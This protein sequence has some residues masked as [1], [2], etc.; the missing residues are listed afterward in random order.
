M[1]HTIDH[2]LVVFTLDYTFLLLFE[3][4]KFFKSESGLWRNFLTSDTVAQN[5]LYQQ[6]QIIDNLRPLRKVITEIN[7]S[8]EPGDFVNI[9]EPQLGN[10]IIT[11]SVNGSLRFITSARIKIL[12]S[13]N[14]VGYK[15]IELT[16]KQFSNL[17][18]Q[19]FSNLKLIAKHY[20][21]EISIDNIDTDFKSINR[22]SPEYF[23]YILGNIDNIAVAEI[24][25][26]ILID[27][28]INKFRLHSIEID[29][30]LIP[31]IG[32]TDLF[33]FSLVAQQLKSNIYV[34]DLLPELFNSK[35]LLSNFKQKIYITAKEATQ[36]L[37][38]EKL[39]SNIVEETKDAYITQTIDLSKVKLDSFSLHNQSDIL[40]IML[41]NGTFIQLPSL[42]EPNNFQIKV[43]GR[44]LESVEE[45]VHELTL[46]SSKYYSLYISFR[47]PGLFNSDLE[48][49]IIYLLQLK[50]TVVVT[51]NQNGIEIV[52][53]KNE[54][55]DV[56]SGLEKSN[57]FWDSLLKNYEISIKIEIDNRQKEFISGKK[58]GKMVKILNNFVQKPFIQFSPFNEYN[59]FINVKVF[60]DIALLIKCIQLIE[61]E[62]P[63]EVQ[64]NVP[65]VFHKSIIGNGGSIIQSIMKKYNVFIKF[66]SN[67]NK[68]GTFYSFK[69]LNNV[70]IKCPQ[71]NAKNISFVKRDIAQLVQQCCMNLQP[72]ASNVAVYHNSEFRLLKSHYLLLINNFKLKPVMDLEASY[73]SF[74]S[75]PKSLEDF[76]RKNYVMVPIKGSDVKSKQAAYKLKDIL[77]HN[78]EF[79]L[80]N[81]ADKFCKLINEDNEEFNE[82]IIMP[83]RL[84]LEVELSF[85]EVPIDS[86]L[87]MLP[88]IILS[89]YKKDLMKIAIEDLTFYLR[90]K[91]F[92]IL[93]KH[94]YN[95]NPIVDNTIVHPQQQLQSQLH[96][97]GVR[98]SFQTLQP[99]T[100][101]VSDRKS[102]PKSITRKKQS[103]GVTPTVP[104]LSYYAPTSNF[105]G[106]QII[107]NSSRCVH[108]IN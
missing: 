14:K 29:L 33:D 92:L 38:A 64:F 52:G 48:Y 91:N 105:W 76:G 60:N 58:N 28:M 79:K 63:A 62:I 16:E 35:V 19:F 13:Y 96:A 99:I 32:G 56:L 34:P 85:N 7:Y 97:P 87:T 12:Q 107:V 59:F 74:I 40:N 83:L 98:H 45:S 8:S 68:N 82:K 39:V 26:R 71:K 78:F 15:K 10:S 94:D 46:L 101:N 100:N 75:L 21:V 17:D 5:C 72:V 20:N 41:K 4:S 67:T 6:Y 70:L 57:S 86:D 73:N 25:T 95:Y 50:K 77:P 54:I 37:L 22:S 93:E 89:G 84:V 1:L 108:Y 23:I 61:L 103:V 43:Q 24:Q 90:E 44:T 42:G 106:Q 88:Q 53:H 31:L 65:E 69:R 66:S 47:D 51:Y 80:A 36:L 11:F 49:H 3:N 27:S 55:F 9:L 2:N 81:N 30:S 102:K 18:E 104:S